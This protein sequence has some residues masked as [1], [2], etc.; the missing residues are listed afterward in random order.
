MNKVR[1]IAE[2]GVNHNG[3]EDLALELIDKAHES[4]ADIVKFQ[5]FKS[6]NLVTKSAQKAS[7]QLKNTKK[8]E[9][10]FQMLKNL[11]LSQEVF[12]R[13]NK[14]SLEKGLEFIST[15]FDLDSLDFLVRTLNISELKVASGELTNAPLL[16]E[17]ARTKRDIILSTG[18][19]NNQEIQKAL[20]II[21]FGYLSENDLDPDSKNLEQIINSVSAQKLLEQKVTL[22]HCTTRYPT[23][24]EDTNLNSIDSLR[25]LFKLGIGFSD[26]TSSLIIP[27]LA[28]IKG[29]TI[30]EKHFTLDNDLEGPDHKASLD[31]SQFKEMVINIRE[32]ESSLGNYEK[33]LTLEEDHNRS[34]GR[35]S[36]HVSQDIKKGDKFT[37]DNIIS[38]RPG[39]GISTFRFWEILG[40]KAGKDYLS[41]DLVDE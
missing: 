12:M 41:G 7:Y 33:K 17:H 28:V 35:R 8:T 1:V 20:N 4:G 30:I 36:I 40:K 32:A 19:A 25:D 5:S 38:L 21:A 24:I 18:M 9:S 2:I 10:Q 27:A 6:E 37:K 16:L 15:A 3:R 13:L 39:N 34:L 29:V 11:E 26:H 14:Y 31:P 23:P 22:L